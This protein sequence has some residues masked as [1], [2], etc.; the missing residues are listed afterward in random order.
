MW[1]DCIRSAPSRKTEMPLDHNAS[2]L[3]NAVDLYQP[4]GDDDN[5]AYDDISSLRFATEVNW[6]R[7]TLFKKVC[8]Q[9]MKW[10][11]RL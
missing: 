10:L 5:D 6:T 8:G 9:N 7:L 1:T 2:I 3:A 4:G 11:Y